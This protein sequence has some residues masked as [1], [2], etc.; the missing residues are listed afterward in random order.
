VSP[1]S[2]R[3]WGLVTKSTLGCSGMVNGVCTAPM[4]P[5]DLHT[6]AYYQAVN[7][8]LRDVT[9]RD[10]AMQ[11]LGYIRNQLLNGA[12]RG[13]KAGDVDDLRTPP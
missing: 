4:T 1:H 11:M 10:E 8:A 9:S 7:R 3:G 2:W 5:N 6:R 13:E 12:F